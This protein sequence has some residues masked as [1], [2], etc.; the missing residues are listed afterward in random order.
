[1]FGKGRLLIVHIINNPLF[2]KGISVKSIIIILLLTSQSCKSPTALETTSHNFTWQK[3]VIGEFQSNLYDVWGTDGNNV[4]ATG[5]VRL[6]GKP[7]GILHYDGSQWQPESYAGGYAIYSFSKNDIWCAGGA[8]FHFDGTTWN[9][10]D[11]K[12]VNSQA[13]PLDSVLFYNTPYKAI[14]GTSSSNLYFVSARVRETVNIIHWD[15][16]TASIVYTQ[17]SQNDFGYS[18]INGTADNNIW[19]TG[20]KS[21]TLAYFLFQYDGSIWK[22]DHSV[23]TVSTTVLPINNF[24]TIIGGLGVYVGRFGNWRDMNFPV[25]RGIRKIRGK[26]INDL[27]AVG[28]YG[29]V[30]H[31]NGVSWDVYDEL[32]TPSGGL[33]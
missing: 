17:V 30:A 19:A 8:V 7:Y 13:I 15:G 5:I 27:F 12:I 1:M 25:D 33:N 20:L 2:K 18:D 22:Q 6:N 21:N 31:F 3:Y 32:Y 16:A 28:E 9:Q 23:P 11:S 10:I 26:S 4:Y 24:D 14:W 29:N